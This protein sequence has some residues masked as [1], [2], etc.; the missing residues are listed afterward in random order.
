MQELVPVPTEVCPILQFKLEYIK[1]QINIHKD[2]TPMILGYVE[3][4]AVVNEHWE[5]HA[6]M[7][8]QELPPMHTCGLARL[9]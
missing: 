6:I 3:I 2:P 4:L 5:L 1:K 9:F 7:L 8:C